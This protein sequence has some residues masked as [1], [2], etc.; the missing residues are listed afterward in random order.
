MVK[1]YAR[2]TRIVATFIDRP[3]AAEDFSIVVADAI[4]VIEQMLVWTMHACYRI[5]GARVVGWKNND[6]KRLEIRTGGTC[7][8]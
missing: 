7:R 3:M 2:L 6:K 4:V 1:A 5:I 8:S